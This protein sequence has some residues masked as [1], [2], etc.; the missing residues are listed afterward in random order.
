[1]IRS[2]RTWAVMLSALAVISVGLVASPADAGRRHG[3]HEQMTRVPP[4]QVSPTGQSVATDCEADANG[5]ESWPS[6]SARFSLS[7][8]NGASSVS[9]KMRHARPDTYY[10]L[11]LRLG[12]LT[13]TETRTVV[14]HS[15]T[16]RR[17]HSSTLRTCP[18]CSP[19][20]GPATATP[21]SRTGC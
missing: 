21:L 4:E 3:A 20:P 12:G 15:P 6:A 16:F 10:T 2:I 18:S 5:A 13:R 7:Q 9:I 8:H 17:H 11:W 1:M 14:A 19:R